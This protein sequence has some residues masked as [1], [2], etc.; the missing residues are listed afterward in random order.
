MSDLTALSVPG[1]FLTC[2]N[3]FELI[4]LGR[5]F[6]SDYATCAIRLEAAHIHLLRWG[7]AVDITNTEALQAKLAAYT[8][9]D[10][11][12]AKDLLEEIK[13]KFERAEKDSGSF[14]KRAARN[15]SASTE[16][17][18]EVLDPSAELQLASKEHIT[19]SKALTKIKHGYTE[20]LNV[21]SG[22]HN[23]TRWALY[24]KKNLKALVDEVSG[25]VTELEKLFP[26]IDPE[27]TQRED[28][29][30]RDEVATLDKTT[31][32]LLP[33]LLENTDPCFTAAVK[34]VEKLRGL[35][36]R[37]VSIDG[38]GIVHMGNKYAPN[39]PHDGGSSIS[40][41]SL[42]VKGSANS[43]IGHS[44]GAAASAEGLEYADGPCGPEAHIDKETNPPPM[45][46]VLGPFVGGLLS[47]LAPSNL[48]TISLYIISAH[49][50]TEAPGEGKL[51]QVSSALK[52][53]V[54]NSFPVALDYPATIYPTTLDL[55]VFD[56]SQYY[57]E[58]PEEGLAAM[59]SLVTDYVNSCGSASR[60]VLLG[61]SQG[62]EVVSEVLAGA[63]LNTPLDAEYTEYSGCPPRIDS[64]DMFQCLR[65]T[66]SL[67]PSVS[68]T[69]PSSPTLPTPPKLLSEY[70]GKYGSY[71]T[72]SDYY[73][74]SG[75]ITPGVDADV[76]GDI[77][78]VEVATRADA[79]VAFVAGLAGDS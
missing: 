25:L 64:H 34:S 4:Q 70:G 44:F 38:D 76:A 14:K 12:F 29:L 30:A 60:I 40:I 53:K 57:P 54:P 61:Y 41:G 51:S 27:M 36:I 67:Q 37:D 75:M 69:P 78:G 59:K 21:V 28:Q 52:A 22:A 50:S 55:S 66:Q 47:G 77:H 73:C 35:D 39:Q 13:E 7:K 31:L 10:V 20:A 16:T 23:R 74:S 62:G 18:T 8:E 56:P 79:A 5:N 63:L 45:T 68:A 71:C 58:S 32:E 1:L 49:G 3:Y 9:E 17:D 46:R 72:E 26:D 2:V 6:K 43:H 15:A 33:A 42:S 48:T 24:Q 11:D 65:P 19:A